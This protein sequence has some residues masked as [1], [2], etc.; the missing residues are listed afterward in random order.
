[1]RYADRCGRPRFLLTSTQ[2]RESYMLYDISDGEPKRL[3][4][5]KSPR[6]LEEKFLVEKVLQ[7]E[8]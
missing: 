6:K 7:E 8:L 1:M 2:N 5:D 4:K 3:G